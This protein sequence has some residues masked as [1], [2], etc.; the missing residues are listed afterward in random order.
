M[1]NYFH[2]ALCFGLFL[3][4]PLCLQAQTIYPQTIYQW[5]DEQGQTH[6]GD[7]PPH[8]TPTRALDPQRSTVSTIGG[9]GLRDEEKALLERYA[10]EAQQRLAQQP[11]TPPV[12]I[13]NPAAEPQIA[14]SESSPERYIVMTPSWHRWVDRRYRHSSVD[15]RFQLGGYKPHRPHHPH[16]PSQPM[17]PL[18]PPPPAAAKPRTGYQRAT[19]SRAVISHTGGQFKAPAAGR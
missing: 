9:S 1:D 11:A 7:I 17:Q 6:Y 8:S 10:E 12:I 18:E 3:L 14:E 19:T 13:V 16:R 5:V 2:K 4:A 15:L